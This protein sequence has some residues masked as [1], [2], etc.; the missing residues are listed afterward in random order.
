MLVANLSVGGLESFRE[1]EIQ[2]KR[3]IDKLNTRIRGDNSLL[4]RSKTNVKIDRSEDYNDQTP[5]NYLQGRDGDKTWRVLHTK[6]A[7]LLA[8]DKS[9][10]NG[11]QSCVESK[12]GNGLF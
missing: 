11:F 2:T 5:L 8:Y 10:P 12:V 3:Q 6:S 7:K 1:G 9:Q 4:S